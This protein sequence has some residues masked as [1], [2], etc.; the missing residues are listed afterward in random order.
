MVSRDVFAEVSIRA[1]EFKLNGL[2]QQ[3]GIVVKHSKI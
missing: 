2:A 3:R 1:V